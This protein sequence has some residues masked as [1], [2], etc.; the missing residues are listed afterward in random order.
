MDPDRGRD[1]EEEQRNHESRAV[2]AAVVGG[3]EEVGD[4]HEVENEVQIEYQH[5]PSEQ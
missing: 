4:D 3:V 5:I 1:R 2:G